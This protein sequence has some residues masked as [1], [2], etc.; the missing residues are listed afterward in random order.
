MVEADRMELE[1][2]RMKE[3]QRTKLGKAHESIAEAGVEGVLDP[4]RLMSFHESQWPA[5]IDMAKQ[6]A[7]PARSYGSGQINMPA[8]T[9]PRTPVSAVDTFNA[10]FD[11]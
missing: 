10:A 9:A 4:E 11:G 8:P 5:L 3:A 6:T 1:S 2:L 7:G